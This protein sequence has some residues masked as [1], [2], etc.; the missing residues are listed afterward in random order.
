MF[1]F[2]TG[3]P[4]KNDRCHRTGRWRYQVVMLYFFVSLMKKSSTTESSKTFWEF[5]FAL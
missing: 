4:I 1:R 5:C 2:N 3:V